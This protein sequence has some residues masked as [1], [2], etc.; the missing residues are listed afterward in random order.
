MNAPVKDA[1]KDTRFKPHVPTERDRKQVLMMVGFGITQLQIASIMGVSQD[2]LDRHYR[3]ELD[4]GVSR[5]NMQV[6]NN[7]FAIATSR[8]QGAVAA[9]IFWMKTR[10]QW[11][12]V[13]R[14]EHTGADGG[15]INVRTLI[16]VS[17]M[18]AEE[19]ATLGRALAKAGVKPTDEE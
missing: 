16:D 13:E 9:A 19:Q 4:S 3:N 15:P 8:G 14:H 1:K 7:L 5:A 17:Q 18:T 2:T 12:E 6:A 11:R 10:A